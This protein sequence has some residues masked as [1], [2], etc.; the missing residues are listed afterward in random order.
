MG[1]RRMRVVQ[2][3]SAAS[4]AEKGSFSTAATPSRIASRAASV[5]STPS[6]RIQ[7]NRII[8]T[9]ITQIRNAASLRRV[10][11]GYSMAFSSVSAPW[12]S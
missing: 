8:E 1:A 6:V 11:L 12:R 9:I 4:S 2:F 7:E 3:S 5:S 10:Q